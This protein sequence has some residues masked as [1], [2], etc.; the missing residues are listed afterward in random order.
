MV[1]SFRLIYGTASVEV[2]RMLCLTDVADRAE[3]AEYPSH[4]RAASR[5]GLH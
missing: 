4:S 5:P 1:E 3:S 2:G